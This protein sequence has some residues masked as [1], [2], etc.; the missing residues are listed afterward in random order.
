MYDLEKS[1]AIAYVKKELS[2]DQYEMKEMLGE[3]YI[4]TK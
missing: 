1:E 4:T 2:S 3:C